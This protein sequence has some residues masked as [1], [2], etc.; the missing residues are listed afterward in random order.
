MP[1]VNG[2]EG[3]AVRLTAA[4]GRPFGHGHDPRR[5]LGGRVSRAVVEFREALS[6]RLPR[7]M[8]IVDEAL[9]CDDPRRR[10]A[11]AVEVMDRVI[12]KPKSVEIDSREGGIVRAEL[13]EIFGRLRAALAPEA[14][15]ALVTALADAERADAERQ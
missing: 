5:N 15:K 10:D 8:E 2:S 4:P 12:G 13:Q 14:Y 7:A 11:M 3:S 1:D 6:S 9:S